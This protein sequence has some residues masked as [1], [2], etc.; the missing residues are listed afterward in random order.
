MQLKVS[1]MTFQ[2]Q[3]Q[4]L[5]YSESFIV[6]H[7]QYLMA[8]EWDWCLKGPSRKKGYMYMYTDY[9]NIQDN[10]KQKLSGQ[11]TSLNRAGK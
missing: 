6:Q 9:I 11:D 8:L 3:T 10:L 2:I 1:R 5:V 7:Q 4:S